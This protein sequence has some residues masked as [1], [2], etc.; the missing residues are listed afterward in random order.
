MATQTQPQASSQHLGAA[1]DLLDDLRPLTQDPGGD[2]QVKATA[3]AAHA[4]LVLAEQIAVVRVLMASAG[5]AQLNGETAAP[6]G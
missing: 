1:R 5:A 3:A 4:I 2:A 6:Q